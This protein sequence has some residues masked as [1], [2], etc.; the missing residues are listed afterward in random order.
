MACKFDEDFV[1]AFMVC[2]IF[3]VYRLCRGFGFGRACRAYRACAYRV[4]CRIFNV[5][6]RLIVLIRLVRFLG[7]NRCLEF[8]R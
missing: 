4:V 1:E 3:S 2:W 7:V 8:A 6:C 5:L